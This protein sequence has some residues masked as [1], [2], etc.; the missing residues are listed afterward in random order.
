MCVLA[1]I[2]TVHVCNHGDG[3]FT[4]QH[5]LGLRFGS[6]SSDYSLGP[7]P[8]RTEKMRPGCAFSVFAFLALMT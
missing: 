8:V 6:G 1:V 5:K 2:Y 7:G 4:G 3:C